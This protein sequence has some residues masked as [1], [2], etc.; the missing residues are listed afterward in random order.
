M[1]LALDLRLQASTPSNHLW[2]VFLLPAPPQF[3]Y[4]APPGAQ[5]LA[6]P[7]FANV[8]HL[9]HIMVLVIVEVMDGVLIDVIGVLTISSR[10]GIGRR[11]T[12]DLGAKV[13]T[14]SD[15]DPD[16]PVNMS[17]FVDFELTQAAPQSFC[18][19]DAA[20]KNISSILA[21][22]DTSHLEISRLNAVAQLNMR[23]MSVTL[24]TSH[25][26]RSPLNDVACMNM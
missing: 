14:V 19:K 24:D 23:V 18:L 4:Q 25:F 5:Q 9:G 26:E 16:V 2:F 17:I 8:P 7:D 10:S 3:L 20:F 15:I 1:A 21:T 12:C 22:L 6:L 11:D 13:H